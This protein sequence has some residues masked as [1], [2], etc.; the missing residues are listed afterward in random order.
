MKDVVIDLG[1]E[2]RK[3]RF[4]VGTLKLIGKLPEKAEADKVANIQGYNEALNFIY[5]GMKRYCQKNNIPFN[6]TEQDVE[7]WVDELSTQE[8]INL[9][10]FFNEA[11]SVEDQEGTVGEDKKK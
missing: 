11:Y 7:A 9:F 10:S 8:M 3:L 2:P 5:C 6:T 4:D 1:G